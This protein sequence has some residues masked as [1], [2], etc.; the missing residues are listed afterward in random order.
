MADFGSSEAGRK[1]GKARAE[2]LTPTQRREIARQAAVARWQ[3]QPDPEGIPKAICGSDD[4]PLDAQGI[5]INCYVLDTEQRVISQRGLK[6][7][8]GMNPTGGARRLTRFVA[9]LG[10]KPLLVNELAVRI[11]S[12][13]KFRRESGG[14]V[15][16]YEATLLADICDAVLDARRH[17]RLNHQQA[18]IAAQCEVLVRGFARVGIN[19]LVDEATGYQYLRPRRALAE[20]LERYISD[21]LLG[22]AKRFPDEFYVEMFRLK[23]WDYGSLQPG[24]NK[25]GVVGK[26]TRD[27]VYQ[28]LAPGVIEELERLN[29]VV[30]PGRRRNKHHQWMSEDIGHA[31]LR[32]RL[33]KVITV[34]RLSREWLD[35]KT[36]LRLVLP[37]KWD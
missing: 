34:M 17:K 27:I 2:S 36:K 35:F 29:P 20:I 32:E 11:N 16:G 12:P 19:A 8:L 13:I 22:W 23:G 4:K 30:S 14:A 15:H 1:G 28:R 7:G 25:P 31:E 26:Y 37:K 24:A 3:N 9:S 21:K 6:D 10:G 33:A 5:K 18:H